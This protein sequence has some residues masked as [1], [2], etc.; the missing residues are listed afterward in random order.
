MLYIGIGESEKIG[1]VIWIM[2]SWPEMAKKGQKRGKFYISTSD[3]RGEM[4]HPAKEAKNH[5]LRGV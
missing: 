3:A 2:V 1:A 4:Y 5:V